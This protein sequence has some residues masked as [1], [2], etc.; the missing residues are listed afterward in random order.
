MAGL[1]KG[2][3]LFY[4]DI[5]R[6][7]W[8]EKDPFKTV[9]ISLISHPKSCPSIWGLL[10][11]SQ[12]ISSNEKSQLQRKAVPTMWVCEDVASLE[13]KSEGSVPKP[14]RQFLPRD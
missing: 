9:V 11:K 10:L 1:V 14:T 13:E 2:M 7:N 12:N 5:C 3:G 4:K 6:N 8:D